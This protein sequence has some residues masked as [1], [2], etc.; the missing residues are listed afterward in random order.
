MRSSSTTG[1][2][3]ESSACAP[4]WAAP[5]TIRH[6]IQ[7][8]VSHTSQAQSH[9][10]STSTVDLRGMWSFWD[11]LTGTCSLPTIPWLRERAHTAKYPQKNARLWSHSSGC[12]DG[13]PHA[14]TDAAVYAQSLSF[15]LI[16]DALG[17]ASLIAAWYVH[18]GLL[19]FRTCRYAT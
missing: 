8:E 16:C 9:W 5:K 15:S 7:G 14:Q 12:S 3:H 13:P 2:H 19:G 10:N 18:A 17:N 6:S 4:N 11:S 1:Q